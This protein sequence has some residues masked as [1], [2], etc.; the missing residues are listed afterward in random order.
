MLSSGLFLLSLVLLALVMLAVLGC[1]LYF[2]TKGQTGKT[3]QTAPRTVTLRQD[4]LR[5]SFREAVEL[6]EANIASRNERYNIP[7][8][9]VLNEGENAAQLPIS[10]SGVASMLS[11]ESASAAATQGIAWEFFDR[12]IVID[13][14]GA[15]LGAPDDDSA[16]KPWDAFLGLCRTYRPQ[17][18]FDSLVLTIPAALLL[19]GSADARL[20]LTRRAKLAHR[21]LWLA[22]NRFAMRFAV[23]LVIS[24]CEHVPGF[25]T[26]AR[27]LPENMRASMLGWSSPYDLST[28]YQSERID[29]AFTGILH[30]VSDIGAEV[31][32][33]DASPEQ[34]NAICMLPSRI[35]AMREQIRLYTD[36]LM[37]P[38]AYHEPFLLRGLYLTG[39]SSESLERAAA[40]D[41]ARDDD[42]AAPEAAD[43]WRE[44]RFAAAGAAAGE[45]AA[46]GQPT[47]NASGRPGVHHDLLGQL[48]L[49]PAFLRDLFE[50]KIFQER[51]LTRPSR[52][53]HLSR[54]VLRRSLRWGTVAVLGIWGG[55]IVVAGVQLHSRGEQWIDALRQLHRDDVLRDAML[56][57]GTQPS[58]D[59]DR[60]SALTL[61][62]LNERFTPVTTATVFI[63]GAWPLFDN[64]QTRVGARFA[65][66]FG[67]TAMAAVRRELMA[68]VSQLTGTD[69]DPSTGQLVIGADCRAPDIPNNALGRPLGLNADDQPEMTS[70][71][72]YVAAVDRL[73]AALEALQRLQHPSTSSADDL[74]T[75]IGYALGM[76][77][78]GDIARSLP[79]FYQHAAEVGTV[80]NTDVPVMRNAVRC[81][82]DKGNTRLN[83]RLFANNPLV[84]A[85]QAVVEGLSG[86]AIGSGGDSMSASMQRYK[87]I[88]DGIQ[89]E[90]NLIASG[91]GA[92]MRPNGPSLGSGYDRLLVRVAHNAMLGPEASDRM[93]GDMQTA[94]SAFRANAAQRFDAPD[95]GVQWQVKENRFALSPDRAALR[96]ALANL[97]NQPFMSAPRG[98]TLPVASVGTVLSWD[99]PQLDHVVGLEDVRKHYLAEG[100]AHVAPNVQPALQSAV[101]AQFAA[102]TL[103]QLAGAAVA[104]PVIAGNDADVAGFQN[105]LPKLVKIAG[106]LDELGAHAQADAVRATISAD[107]LQHLQTVDNAL[108]SSELYAVSRIAPPQDGVSAQTM[109]MNTFGVRDSAGL[110]AYLGQQSARA[111]ALG[112]QAGVYLAALTPT[113]ATSPMAVRWQAI[114]R[115]IERYKLKNPNSALLGIEQFLMRFAGAPGTAPSAAAPTGS[116]N[117]ANSGAC[118]ARLEGSAPTLDGDYFSEIYQRLWLQ[119]ANRCARQQAQS[120]RQQWERFALAFN[121]QLAG[122]APFG[123]S[124]ARPADVGQLTDVMTR[125]EDA[126]VTLPS[127]ATNSAYGGDNG[128]AAV[129]RFARQMR[130]IDTF[131]SPLL[132]RDT[133]TGSGATSDAAGYD[134]HM[135]FRTNRGAESE[136][137]QIIDWSLQ[138]GTQ[139]VHATDAVRTVR[140]TV[141]TP[142]TLTL[143]IAKNSPFVALT[144]DAQVEMDTDGRTVNYRFS[145]PWALMTMLQTLRVAEPGMGNDARA[146]TL[147]L[148]FP[149]GAAPQPADRNATKSVVPMDPIARAAA[150]RQA[151]VFVQMQVTPA[152]KQNALPWPGAFPRQA[153]AWHG[154]AID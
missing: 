79:Y 37:R 121:Q 91:G 63:P 129:Q 116:G 12:G 141:G 131:L 1:V 106:F 113:D 96:D 42:S 38:S 126:A 103:D 99:G 13:L 52:T 137:N 58:P 36:E 40:L 32:A 152:G 19:D 16:E 70:L 24:E 145:D 76:Q 140:W 143:R 142:L 61:L 14:K 84:Q 128:G 89:A 135:T 20:E 44:P 146:T 83:A 30:A 62:G 104:I 69:R 93:R 147:Q 3:A 45:T 33:V 73:Q 107:A 148:S 115:D 56:Q 64:L 95:S 11:A 55:G 85:D 138:S 92:W 53:Q 66:A 50:R 2:A 117:A 82:L 125:W 23:Y 94:L 130:A 27:A 67:D 21:R 153:P 48:S 112:Q 134:L 29:A 28:Q 15:Y 80:L 139:I 71:Q 75:L 100:L 35:D 74:R 22:Q 90:N 46:A 8:V 51:G 49:Q 119:L 72:G 151:R 18:P 123:P 114:E 7:W 105:A 47:N 111:Q 17:R 98:R 5:A 31:L 97:M 10:Q 60:R 4:S 132:A 86:I 124:A 54:P 6:I 65:Q 25:S 102:V 68:R 43:D 34:A 81:T 59:W 150:Q 149:M 136:G 39:D 57:D 26:F 77:P 108:I 144:D 88:V 133:A 101:D 78:Q 9:L 118:M 109:L 120:S 154:T 41:S 127:Q 110:A 87:Q 122:T